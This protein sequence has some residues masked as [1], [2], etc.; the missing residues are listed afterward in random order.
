MNKDPYAVLGVSRNAS[1]EEIKSAYRRLARQYHPDHYA[2]DPAAAREAEEKMKEI[3]EAYELLTRAPSGNGGSTTFADIRV[4][5]NHGLFAEAEL[6]LDRMPEGSHTAEWHYLK[7]V[8][9]FRRG[10]QNDAM[11]EIEMACMMEPGNAEYARAREMYRGRFSS[12]GSGY[13]RHRT[14]E[15][16]GPAT[17]QTTGG[18]SSCDI[19]TG[20]MCADCCCESFGFDLI[21]C[22]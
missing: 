5:I 16:Y 15:R 17:R 7:S 13:D 22:L 9:L 19:C 21:R 8:L 3:N 4:K 10:W 6:L 18:C 14:D 12:F 20:L 11:R 1:E 2:S